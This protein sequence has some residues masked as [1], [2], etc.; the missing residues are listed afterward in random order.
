MRKTISFLKWEQTFPLALGICSNFV[1][2]LVQN[3][4]GSFFNPCKN[5]QK[6]FSTKR[7]FI[8]YAKNHFF[9]KMGTNIPTSS[10][11]LL[12][13]CEVIGSKYFRLIIGS[14]QK[15]SKA[16]FDKKRVH[17]LL[18]KPILFQNGYEHSH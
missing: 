15:C 3:I 6:P 7:E 16:I 14:L 4:S 11:N 5:A 2:S 9:F 17:F 18:E 8:F 13:F 10:R 1:K 12:K